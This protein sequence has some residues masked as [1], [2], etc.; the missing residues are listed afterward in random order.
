MA[1]NKPPR[2][3]V[4]STPPKAAPNPKHPVIGSRVPPRVSMFEHRDGTGIYWHALPPMS[5]DAEILQT[6]L[7]QINK[8]KPPS[9]LRRIFYWSCCYQPDAEILQA[10][11]LQENKP[12]PP[13]LLRR[14]FNWITV[15]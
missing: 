7:L 2:L 9:L 3:G 6:A 14:I 10:A 11:L 4:P 5:P 13:S 15:A 8:P 12:K 1:T